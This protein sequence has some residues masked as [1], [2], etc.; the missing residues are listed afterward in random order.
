VG[1]SN[2]VAWAQEGGAAEGAPAGG[3]GGEEAA[4]PP[5]VESF[6]MWVVKTSGVIGFV[7]LLL[8]IYFVATVARMFYELRPQIAMP[9][10][11][12][13]EC[14]RLLEQRDFKGMFEL[15]QGDDSLISRLLTTGI[16][17]LPNGVAEA[18]EAM[19]RLSEAT[20]SEMEKKISMLAVLGTLGPMIGLL[21]TLQGMIGA[22]S[23]IARSDTGM[24]ASEV[25]K[26][27]SEALL[28]TFEGVAL[29]VPSIYFFALFRN[30]VV[31]M[32]VSAMLQADNLLRHFH[33][34]TRESKRPAAAPRPAPNPA[35]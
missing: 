1:K 20:T 27:I 21:G 35:G 31:F 30:R 29:S 8:S 15:V 9:P 23:V 17:E 6:F 11:I 34:A 5:E 12:I 33:H 25:A 3:G 2:H 32:S 16:S 22:F 26:G 13:G 18:R 7:I 19:E 24:K 14:E 10:E 4:K 28:L